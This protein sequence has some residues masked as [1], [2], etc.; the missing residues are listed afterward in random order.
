M[1]GTGAGRGLSS[2]PPRVRL[3]VPYCRRRLRRCPAAGHAA[4]RRRGRHRT[5]RERSIDDDLLALDLDRPDADDARLPAAR[6]VIYTIA[7][8]PES[9]PG[10]GEPRLERFLAALPAPPV[11]FVYLSTSGV[12]GDCG[13]ALV[14]E[15]RPVAPQTARARRRVAAE[16]QLAGWCE[17]HGVE[18]V[19]LRVPGIYGPGRLGL[20]RLEAGTPVLR[21]ADAGPGN[22]IHV[23]DLVRAVRAAADLAVVPAVCNVGDGDYRSATW[24]ALRVAELAGLPP[25]PRVSRAEAARTFDRRR[26]SFLT[27]SRRLDLARLHDELGVRARFADATDGIRASLAATSD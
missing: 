19:V 5:S 11:R 7:P 18:R 25:P 24:F 2:R 4:G 12:Y 6:T 8:R 14:A 21:E 15:T 27:E 13:G 26:L 9:P 20:E 10:A 16:T 22:R 3:P 1:A 23:D 17:A